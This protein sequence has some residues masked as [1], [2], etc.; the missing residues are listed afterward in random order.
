[1]VGVSETR[2]GGGAVSVEKRVGGILGVG[3]LRGWVGTKELWLNGGMGWDGWLRT[4][5][6]NM[7]VG[8]LGR[9]AFLGS[10]GI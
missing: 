9:D 7:G 4:K 1:M 5:G 8:E 2:G 3:C 10:G 6:G